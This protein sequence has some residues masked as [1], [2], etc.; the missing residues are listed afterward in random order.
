MATSR[1]DATV[2]TDGPRKSGLRRNS[3]GILGAVAITAAFMGPSSSVYFGSFAA[4]SKAG[5][6]Y[7]FSIV[8]AIIGCLLIAHAVA[9]F[10]R[11]LPTAGMA[12]TFATATFGPR[13]GFMTGWL[14]LIGYIPIV[15]LLSAAVGIL[16]EQ[17]CKTYFDVSIPWWVFTTMSILA[18]MYVCNSGVSRSARVILAFLVFEVGVFTALFLTIIVKGG[19]DGNTLAPFNP[20]NSLTG[21]SGIAYG[22]LWAFWMF[23]GFEAAGTLGEETKDPRRNVPRALFAAVLIIGSYYVLSA[24]AAAI[25]FGVNSGAFATDGSPWDTL[26]QTY[27]GG[28]I[29]WLIL[30]TV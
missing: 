5:P 30:L 21:T 28:N 26:S 12:Y 29:G 14:L 8:L 20:G 3:L 25:G 11:K 23:F 9:E 15:S 27:W 18:V 4:M 6:A 2:P 7:A 13:V 10:S 22:V 19:T 17:F 24:Y 16:S 1:A